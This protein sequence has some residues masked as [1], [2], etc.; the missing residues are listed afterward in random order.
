MF[1]VSTVL[2]GFRKGFLDKMRLCYGGDFCFVF[3]VLGQYAFTFVVSREFVDSGFDYLHAPFV[4][5]VFL[6]LLH[7]H[8]EALRFLYQVAKVFRH[9]RCQVCFF[10]CVAYALA[11]YRLHQWNRVLIPENGAYTAKVVPFLG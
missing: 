8:S 4:M 1:M 5:Q 10:Q 7:V 2:F 11:R 3:P 9:R 6:V